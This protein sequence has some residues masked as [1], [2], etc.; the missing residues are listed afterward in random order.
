[1]GDRIMVL[2]EGKIQQ[3]GTPLELY[4]HPANRFVAGFIGSPQMNI[5][6]AALIDGRIVVNKAARIA[7]DPQL[8]GEAAAF[9]AFEVGIRPEHIKY[10]AKKNE[11]S[12]EVEVL[13]VEMM[14]N[15][16]QVV[17][18]LG[19]GLFTAKWPG[20]WSLDPGM[21]IN[22]ELDP[23]RFHFF[24]AQSGGLLRAAAV[25]DSENVSEIMT[26]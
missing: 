9:P 8:L 26:A 11:C 6:S 2:N 23:E 14:G 12:C 13:N 15:E 18:D 24:D 17:F 1:M 21:K 10:A 19:G 16:T 7:A 25:D 5:A 22:V 3:I 4:N 20:Q